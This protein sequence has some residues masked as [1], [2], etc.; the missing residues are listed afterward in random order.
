MLDRFSSAVRALHRGCRENVDE[1]YQAWAL[2][3]IKPLL[4]FD[5]AFWGTGANV[6]GLAVVHTSHRHNL[7]QE[8][9]A[10]WERHKHEDDSITSLLCAQGGMV[11]LNHDALCKT[12]IYDKCWRHFGINHILAAYLFDAATGLYDAIAF[13]RYDVAAP[14][15]DAERQL[16]DCLAPHL[17]DTY[18]RTGLARSV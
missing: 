12:A 16:A 14:F 6:D 3:Q 5:A 18:R 17:I 7:S 2:E 15:T 4:K 8:S 11:A 10:L 13:H 1:G 9:E